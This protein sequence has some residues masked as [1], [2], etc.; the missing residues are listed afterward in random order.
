MP[1]GIPELLA[2]LGQA[3]SA[4][5]QTGMEGSTVGSNMMQLSSSLE[6][7]LK[8][9]QGIA[10]LPQNQPAPEQIAAAPGP[11]EQLAQLSLQQR[12]QQMMPQ[13]PMMMMGMQPAL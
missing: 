1:V 9:M 5:V 11:L 12:R 10:A 8:T 13:N 3:Q 6:K 2:T 4:G 7:L